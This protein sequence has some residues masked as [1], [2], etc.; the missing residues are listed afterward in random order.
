VI[1][2]TTHRAPTDTLGEQATAASGM[3]LSSFTVSTTFAIRSPRATERAKRRISICR[4]I[5]KHPNRQRSA[6]API[7]VAAGVVF[8]ASRQVG[9]AEVNGLIANGYLPSDKRQD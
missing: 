1:G 2:I 4:R 5:T 7:A 6:C 3:V 9:P 8:V